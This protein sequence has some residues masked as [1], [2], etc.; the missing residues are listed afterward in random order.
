MKG[1]GIAENNFEKKNVFRTYTFC[2]GWSLKWPH[3]PQLL[4]LSPLYNPLLFSVDKACASNK[5]WQMGCDFV[6]MLI[7]IIFCFGVPILAQWE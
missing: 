6:I 7:Y 5:K 1:P 2:G 3:D 4:V